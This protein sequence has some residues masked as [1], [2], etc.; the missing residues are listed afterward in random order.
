ML[1]PPLLRSKFGE[2]AD[3]I[4]ATWLWNKIK[5]RSSSRGSDQRQEMLGY[6]DGGFGLLYETLAEDLRRR[7]AQIRLSCPVRR[8]ERV[9]GG[10]LRVTTPAGEEFFDKLMGTD[11]VRRA[12][13]AGESV[14]S[15]CQAWEPARRAYL[16]AR[17][18]A[19]LYS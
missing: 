5:L 12:L 7:G 8:V 10:G 14:K 1:W 6:L 18:E 3:D 16:K 4:G 19:L 17:K 13:K 11:F 15:I 2:H 9:D